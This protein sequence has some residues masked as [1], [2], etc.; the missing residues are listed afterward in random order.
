MAGAVAWVLTAALSIALGYYVQ[1]FYPTLGKYFASLGGV[2]GIATAFIGKSGK[3]L[4]A[5]DA[6]Q[7]TTTSQILNCALALIGPVH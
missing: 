7:Q 5:S 3:T 4:A 6:D 2:A 1:E